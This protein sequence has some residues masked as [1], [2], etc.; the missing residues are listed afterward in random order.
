MPLYPHR[1]RLRGPWER[2]DAGG[3]ARYLR[4]FNTPTGLDPHEQVWLVV[5]C[6]Q[7]PGTVAVNDRSLGPISPSPAE[8]DITADL[9]H[10]NRLLLDIEADQVIGL[11][12]N[13]APGE[14]HLEIRSTWQ[15]G[16]VDG[17]STT[18]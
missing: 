2:E 3:R 12:L 10:H 9:A 4:R 16:M 7:H 1:I 17:G 5:N 15:P 6:D 8:F 11:P 13:S 18:N 14:I